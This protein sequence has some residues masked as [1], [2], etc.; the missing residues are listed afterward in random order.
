MNEC[1]GDD[2]RS[3]SKVALIEIFCRNF[4]LHLSGNW[5][6]LVVLFRRKTPLIPTSFCLT[7][8]SLC[9]VNTAV[10]VKVMF[11]PIARLPCSAVGAGWIHVLVFCLSWIRVYGGNI[12]LKTNWS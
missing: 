4:R 2:T 11:V 10:A 9:Y 8:H 12:K 6:I 1:P 5:P 3:L 7:Q